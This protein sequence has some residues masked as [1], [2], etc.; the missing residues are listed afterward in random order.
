MIASLDPVS[1]VHPG[2]TYDDCHETISP[3]IDPT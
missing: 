2:V 3:I 1:V